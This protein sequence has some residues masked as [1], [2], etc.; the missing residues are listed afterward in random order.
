MK[1]LSSPGKPH[2]I[3][4]ETDDSSIFSQLLTEGDIMLLQECWDVL[5]LLFQPCKCAYTTSLLL[6]YNY[7]SMAIRLKFAEQHVS[8]RRHAE[9]RL[10]FKLSFK[11]E[12]VLRQTISLV[13]IIK[14]GLCLVT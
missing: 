9:N 4:E 1:A 10:D 2:L 7:M 5:V 8:D 13:E 3:S 14:S 6:L 11:A 12:L